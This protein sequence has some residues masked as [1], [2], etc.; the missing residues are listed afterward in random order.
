LE[1]VGSPSLRRR[2]GMKA[3]SLSLGRGNGSALALH[4]GRF[5]KLDIF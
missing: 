3:L 5:P 1:R 4:Y 2:S